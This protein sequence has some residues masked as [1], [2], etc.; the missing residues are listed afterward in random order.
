[1][2]TKWILGV[3]TVVL[4]FTFTACGSKY[5]DALDI[6]K[7]KA[8]YAEATQKGEIYNSLNT[9]AI[10]TATYL[11]QV[12]PQEYGDS[13]Q[14]FLVGVYQPSVAQ[15]DQNL[16]LKYKDASV[17]ILS[18]GEKYKP[19]LSE[20]L[21]DSNPKL[22]EMPLYNS[23]SEYYL[24]VFDVPTKELN[25]VFEDSKYGTISMDFVNISGKQ[26]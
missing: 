15:P 6:N 20:K 24:I 11:N 4:S 9:M 16:G 5:L 22:V 18:N 25:I 23:W 14:S 26:R 7:D 17:Y 21:S 1:M 19:I 8:L 3:L 13:N 12:D 2:S 10:V